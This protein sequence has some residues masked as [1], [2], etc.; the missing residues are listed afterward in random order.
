MTEPHSLK[1][2]DSCK[3]DARAAGHE[4]HHATVDRHSGERVAELVEGAT[5]ACDRVLCGFDAVVCVGSRD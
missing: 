4:F 3:P 2:T 1:Q 5:G